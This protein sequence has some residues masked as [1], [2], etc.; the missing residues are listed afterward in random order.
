MKSLTDLR[1]GLR[2]GLAFTISIAFSVLLALYARGQLGRVNDELVLMVQDRLVKVEQLHTVKDNLNHI[3]R[4]VRNIALLHDAAAQRKEVATIEEARAQNTALLDK[5]DATIQAEKGRRLL[6]AASSAR[7]P[8]NAS[9]Q[10]VI[11]L[12][13][14]GEVDAAR[15]LLL[16]E[17]RPLQQHYMA[18][19]EALIDFQKE[20][21]LD[22]AKSADERVNFAAVTVLA[23]AG[24]AIAIG[25]ALALLI[26]RS[27]VTPIRQA[28][29]AA[30]TVA[31]GDLRLKLDSQRRDE[32]GQLLGALQRMNDALVDIVGAVR[33]NADSLATASGEIAQGNADLSQ[34]TEEQ[35]SSLQQTAASMEEL[36]ATVRHN[37][38]TAQQAAQLVDSAAR[39]AE[40]G[41]QV[42]GQVVDTMA[43]ITAS[44]H[45]IADIIGTIDGIAFQTNI[46]ALNAAVEAARAGEQGRGF[47][48]VAGE[49]RALAQRSAQAA[50]EIKALIGASVERV[51]AG[52]ALV[53]EAGRTMGDM[54]GQVRRVADLI[55]EISAA[56]TEQSKG[57]G[58][59]GEAVSQLDQ[60]T[61]QNAAL[62]EQSAAAAESLRVQ[63]QQLA[64]A[65]ASFK[66]D[67]ATAPPGPAR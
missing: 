26:T 44:S 8:Y 15:D 60:V 64:Q 32:A 9:V 45:K 61:Q 54:V 52:N 1:I 18:A 66:L 53:G 12:G 56:S 14:K 37:T 62:V 57:I 11:E 3:A 59:I 6:A 20:L 27:V 46:L 24:A 49:V 63:A 51:E 35:A 50:R 38:E 16:G 30:E 7:P 67:A 22:A 2:L 21:M 34:R 19:L 25:A 42:M 23:A 58:Q 41:G 43:Q 39:V 47:A 28:V 33:G 5:L 17:T 65:V 36:S 29:V 4:A 48:V 31:T 13:M 10:R 55:G 40:G